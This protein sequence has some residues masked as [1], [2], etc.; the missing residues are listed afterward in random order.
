MIFF[1][2]PVYYKKHLLFYAIYILLLNRT[3]L[4]PKCR[5]NPSRRTKLS[6]IIDIETTIK[7]NE[8]LHEL[9]KSNLY[10]LMKTMQEGKHKVQLT[11]R[12][13]SA[14]HSKNA[15]YA[16]QIYFKLLPFPLEK[17]CRN[18]QMINSLL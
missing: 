7:G 4:F 6:P 16:L 2:K 12:V 3:I 5:K 14:P 11:S 13:N 17:S 10:E 9:I 1:T 18:E 15:I 8:H